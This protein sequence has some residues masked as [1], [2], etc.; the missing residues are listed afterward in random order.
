M[1]IPGMLTTE[2]PFEE[3]ARLRA[4]IIELRDESAQRMEWLRW[5]DEALAWASNKLH[6]GGLSTSSGDEELP[7]LRMSAA[8]SCRTCGAGDWYLAALAASAHDIALADNAKKEA[9]D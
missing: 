7:S 5:H 1:A 6:E 3:C 4:T 9:G 2:S 8:W